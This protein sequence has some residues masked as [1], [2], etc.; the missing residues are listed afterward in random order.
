MRVLGVYASLNQSFPKKTL[1][2]SMMERVWL[3]ASLPAI[4]DDCKAQT[5]GA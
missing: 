5:A 3:Q 1:I 2:N 4:A